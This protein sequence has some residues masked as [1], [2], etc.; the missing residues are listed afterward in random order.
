MTLKWQDINRAIEDLILNE[1][2]I[3]FQ[4]IAISLAKERWP[5]VVATEVKKDGGEDGLTHSYLTKDGKRFRVAS[6]ITNTYEKVKGDLK[7]IYERGVTLDLLIFY[8]PKKVFNRYV[9]DW[10]R[11]IREKFGCELL[12]ISREDIIHELLKPQNHWICSTFLGLDV[13]TSP[14]VND[15][16]QKAIDATH[17]VL[18][19]WKVRSRFGAAR[20]IDLD[21]VK[22]DEKK[23]PTGE[24]FSHHAIC[25][26]LGDGGRSILLGGPGS[27]KTTTL[28]QICERLLTN[29]RKKVPLLVSLPE[30]IESGKDMLSFITKHPYFIATGISPTDLALLHESGLLVFVLNGWNEMPAHL[31]AVA[32]RQLARLDREFPA[33]GIIV[34]TREFDYVPPLLGAL[35]LRLNSITNSQR[36][37]FV[38]SALSE[39]AGELLSRI[40]ADEVLSEITRTPLI[41]SELTEIFKLG[42]EVPRTR[43]GILQGVIRR[44]EE[45]EEHS[46]ALQSEPICGRST[47]YLKEIS[48]YMTQE[49]RTVLH[50]AKALSVI[51]SVNESLKAA[52]QMASLPDPK[53]TLDMLCAHHLLEKSKYPIPSI[54]FIHQQFQELYAAIKVREKISNLVKAENVDEISKFQFNIIN[55]PTWEEPLKLITEEISERTGERG[56]EWTSHVD[57]FEMGLHLVK[58]STPIDPIFAAQLARLCG[59]P[60]WEAVKEDFGSLLR[61][62]YNYPHEAHKACS[63][64][65]MFASGADD[66]SDIIWP[67]LEHPDQQVRL[68]TYRTPNTFF[69]TCLGNDWQNRVAAW[70]AKHR[71]EFV[72]EVSYQGGSEELDAIEKFAL[73]DPST[74]IRVAAMIELGWRGAISK[75]YQLLGSCDD[76]TFRAIVSNADYLLENAPNDL[77]PKIRSAWKEML[78]ESKD[79][80]QRL[81]ILLRLFEA[82]E[83]GVMDQV[84][85]MLEDCTA[86]DLKG[87]RG[88]FLKEVLERVASEDPDWTSNWIARRQA[89]GILLGEQWSTFLDEIPDEIITDYFDSYLDPKYPERNALRVFDLIAKGATGYQIQKTLQKMIELRRAFDTTTDQPSELQR[90]L[91]W[92]LRDL[93]RAFPLSK[94]V[95]V[96][97]DHQSKPRNVSDLF[98]ILDFLGGYDLVGSYVRES[99]QEETL[100][101]LRL[102]LRDYHNAVLREDDFNGK[103]KSHLSTALSIFGEPKDLSLIE[104][105][106]R[107]DIKRRR[108]G[109]KA[110]RNGERDT[111]KVHGFR[112]DYSNWHVRALCRLDPENAEELILKLIEDRFYES[113]AGTGL[114]QLLKGGMGEEGKPQ[115]DGGYTGT[116]KLAGIRPVPHIS[117]IQ[118]QRFSAALVTRVNALKQALK[119]TDSQGNLNY[120]LK[121]LATILA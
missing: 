1:R 19:Q 63:L 57:A 103:L 42:W 60:T 31:M 82:N 119:S 77:W 94:V 102:L 73:K 92:R 15:V 106:I 104:S 16:T 112:M 79:L 33:S 66:F 59:L 50:E 11:K 84:K 67:L 48:A 53:L 52:G 80:N 49:G 38:N 99:L 88:F 45:S 13:P 41:L 4:R 40:E 36:Q 6:S 37:I 71:K 2:G 101:N 109:E 64:A 110:F 87:H 29:G 55:I 105:L 34:A 22:L 97:L 35:N 56:K 113:A 78:S 114:I 5:E 115:F 118:Q 32:G 90:N 24:I 20:L 72:S 116:F 23:R 25:M 27:G 65:A 9:D 93:L 10:K 96:V 51:S 74:E 91:Y 81:R 62:W 14:T 46:I 44:T 75:F 85:A 3:D 8:T 111:P 83:Q 47:E 70:D 86:E 117:K 95:Q 100:E 43:F 18:D 108:Q 76:A 107:A 12:V 30:W 26:H 7:S 28:I 98:L 21:V 61:R 120:R 121:S 17:K 39:R 69:L 68:K 58:W 54:F 89:E